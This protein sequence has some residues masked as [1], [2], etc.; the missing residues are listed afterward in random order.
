MMSTD[1][2]FS[3]VS[4]GPEFDLHRVLKE[5]SKCKATYE[6]ILSDQKMLTEARD[7]N[8]HYTKEFN[9]RCATMT[10]ALQAER[11]KQGDILEK[12]KRKVTAQL[13]EQHRLKSEVQNVQQDIQ[14]MEKTSINLRQ[15]TDVSTAVPERKVVFK[16][17]TSDGVDSSGFEIKPRIV[18]PMEGGTALITFEEDTVAQNILKLK[19]H[20]VQLEQKLTL[21][22]QAL[23]VHLLVPSYVE[24]DTQVC[25]RRVLV[26]NLPKMEAED[27][28]LDKLEIYFSKRKNGGGEVDEADMLHD[29]GNVVIT[30]TESTIAKG[31][32]DKQDHEVEME[33]G[34]RHKVK[35]TPFLNGKIANFQIR[36][37]MCRRTVL[38]T[39][40]PAIADQDSLQ[41]LLEIHFQK[42]SNGGGEVDAIIYNPLG[43]HTLAVFDEDSPTEAQRQ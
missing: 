12:E 38:L 36:D 21:N 3:L 25:P 4:G 27:R 42:T 28:I 26:S 34:K 9:Q 40:I 6:S 1:E 30:F 14:Q 22:V 24:L 13:E 19:D 31:L 29:S 17:Q 41:D 33:K 2:A 8:V 18:Y 11:K 23:P 10:P 37:T 5:I 43:Q 35:V 15:Q 32:T 7:T 39:G 20:E 16:G